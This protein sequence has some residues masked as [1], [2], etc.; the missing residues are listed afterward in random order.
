MTP[1]DDLANADRGRTSH[2]QVPDEDLEAVTGGLLR[3]LDPSGHEDHRVGGRSDS[4][5]DETIDE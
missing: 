5:H 3:P 4:G 1:T 2:G